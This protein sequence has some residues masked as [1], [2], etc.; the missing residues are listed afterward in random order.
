MF[1]CLRPFRLVAGSFP[2]DTE[3]EGEFEERV[4]K[5][6]K[7][8]SGKACGQSCQENRKCMEGLV[9]RGEVT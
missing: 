5:R 9:L 2:T 3:E 1:L 6:G 7:S 4:L 8:I